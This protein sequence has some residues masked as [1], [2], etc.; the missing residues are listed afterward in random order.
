MQ[1]YSVEAAP[2]DISALVHKAARGE[3]VLFTE[4][5]QPLAKIVPLDEA[6]AWRRDMQA[7]E[8]FAKGIP[9][10]EREEDEER[11]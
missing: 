7:L 5:N 8:G 11:G 10:F 9:P 6:A 1:T 3:E 4:N 2:P